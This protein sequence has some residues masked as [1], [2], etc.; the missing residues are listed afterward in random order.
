MGIKTGVVGLGYWG[1]NLVRNVAANPAFEL[2]ALCDGNRAR[3][4]KISAAYPSARSFQNFSE[5][6]ENAQPDLVVVATPVASHHDLAISALRAGC[7]VLVEKPL[8]SNLAEAES[9][10]RVAGDVGRLA[11]VDHTFLFTPAVA[12]IAKLHR[13]GTLGE[14]LYVD[15]VRIA[16]GLFQPDVD[17]VWDLAPHDLAILRHVFGRPPISVQ[18]Q[19]SS[20]NPRA[21]ADVAYLHLDYGS[22]VH[23]HLHLSWLSPVKVRR[24]IFAGTQRSLIFDDLEPT[25]KVKLY[26]HG[27]DFDLDDTESR[28]QLLISY[29]KGEMRAPALPVTEALAAQLAHIATVIRGEASPVAPATDGLEVVRLLEASS[30]SLRRGGERI[31][32]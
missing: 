4:D 6:L 8:A 25:E 13:E 21:T 28:R 15:S 7:H 18:T 27:V 3:L 22:G 2:V 1:P 12:E 20:H 11:F 19:G 24:M 17:V 30:E 14:L 32:L 26:D 31:L 16:L 29:R 5:F 9:I 23:A 10:V